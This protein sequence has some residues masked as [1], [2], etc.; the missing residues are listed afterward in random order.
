MISYLKGKVLAKTPEFI[1]L[2]V[3]DLGYKVFLPK[4]M[5]SQIFE[6]KDIQLF[7]Y[8]HFRRDETAELYGMPSFEQLQLFELIKSIPGIGPKAALSLSSLGGL[9]AIKKAIEREDESFFKGIP[10]VGKKKIQKLILELTG[11]LKTPE[12][13]K[14]DDALDALLSLGFSH[15]EAKEALQKIPREIEDTEARVKEALKFIQK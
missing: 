4:T 5:L 6:G 9:Q 13:Q 1:I 2:G 8:L 15:K 14:K 7:C 12:K 10:G 3:G 11:K